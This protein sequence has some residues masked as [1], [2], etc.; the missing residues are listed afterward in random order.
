MW[1]PAAREPYFDRPWHVETDETDLERVE[2]HSA[3][4]KT[5]D[6]LIGAVVSTFPND[7]FDAVGRGDVMSLST[8]K[9]DRLLRTCMCLRN[10]FRINK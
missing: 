8:Q 1:S 4:M 3:P 7:P 5:G 10:P 2:V 9:L 6:E